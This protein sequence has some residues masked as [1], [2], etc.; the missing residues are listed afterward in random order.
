MATSFLPARAKDIATQFWRDRSGVAAIEFA[1]LI[2][3]MMIM[4]IGTVEITQA[5]HVDRR[6]ALAN[7]VVGDILGR[8]PMNDVSV[9]DY[10]SIAY[11]GLAPMGAV[12]IDTLRMRI[13]SYAVDVGVAG[14]D[15][16]A[17]V[18]WQMTC[19]AG[20]TAGAPTINCS[21]GGTN[22]LLGYDDGLKRCDIDPTVGK[23]VRRAKTPLLRL[24]VRYKHM[25]ILAGM[26]G[27]ND[28]TGWFGFVPE[29]GFELSKQYYTWPRT[30][31]RQEGPKNALMTAKAPASNDPDLDPADPA[32]CAGISGDDG[33]KI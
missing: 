18:D 17:F 28:G 8:N 14:S 16:R 9:A 19:S 23:D 6:L 33:F 24:E 31:L 2:P 7:R 15:P 10:E 3:V 1:L 21:I 20:F 27:S 26:F 4:Y 30:L 12:S 11:A 25:P 29:A 13:T 32:V 22:A 5:V